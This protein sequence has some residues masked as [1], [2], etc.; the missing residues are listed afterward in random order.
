MTNVTKSTAQDLIIRG[1]SV[2]LCYEIAIDCISPAMWVVFE[3]ASVLSK[4]ASLSSSALALSGLWVMSAML[5]TPFIAMQLWLPNYSKR[6]TVTK[7]ANIGLI[8]GSCVW[9]FMAWLSRDLDYKFAT[10]N[11][12]FNGTGGMIM[13]TLFALILNE[14]QNQIEIDSQRADL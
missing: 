8:T 9:F 3:N 7:L 12:L 14:E 10:L 2:L 13:A 1:L 6:R 5:L 4:I 11:F